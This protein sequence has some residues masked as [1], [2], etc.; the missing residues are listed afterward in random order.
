MLTEQEMDWLQSGVEQP[1]RP[2][3]RRPRPPQ[4]ASWRRRDKRLARKFAA[5][6]PAEVPH[7]TNV[8]HSE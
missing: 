4:E 7:R 1:G 5:A 6:M 3:P 8:A 2:T